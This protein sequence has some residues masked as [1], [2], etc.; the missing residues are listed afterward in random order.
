MFPGADEGGYECV[1]K[2]QQN[3]NTLTD[4][5][6][7]DLRFSEAAPVAVDKSS[8]NYEIMIPRIFPS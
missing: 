2:D 1:L 7:S 8:N 4:A 3:A 6:L 5:M